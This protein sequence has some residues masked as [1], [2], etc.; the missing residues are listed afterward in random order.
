M[1]TGQSTWVSVW[2]DGYVCLSALFGLKY[3]GNR[4]IAGLLLI[5]SIYIG[6]CAWG[7]EWSR[8]RWRHCGDVI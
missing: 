1:I 4:E 5:E 3:L 6:K 8:H 2:M 7:V